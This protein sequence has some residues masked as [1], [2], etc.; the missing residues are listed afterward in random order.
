M[1]LIERMTLVPDAPV[2][3]LYLPR[4]R[5]VV[6][7]A[8]AKEDGTWVQEEPGHETKESAEDVLPIRSPHFDAG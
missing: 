4:V 2:D 8:T 6:A 3:V 1:A 7:R 5:A